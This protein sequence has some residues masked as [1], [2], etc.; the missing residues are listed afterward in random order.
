MSGKLKV[1]LVKSMIGR[2]EK[3]RRI[4]RSMGLAKI[5]RTVEFIDTPSIRGMI[6]KVLHLVK[7]EEKID[8]A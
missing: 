8:E 7:A 3:H 4:L 2:P 6:N 5:N 1:T